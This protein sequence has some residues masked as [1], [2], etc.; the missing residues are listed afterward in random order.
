MLVQR[1]KRIDYII[2]NIEYDKEID[3]KLN[4]NILNLSSKK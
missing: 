3:D 4:E 1:S 2:E